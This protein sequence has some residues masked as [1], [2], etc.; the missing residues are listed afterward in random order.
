ME[1]EPFTWLTATLTEERG[2]EGPLGLPAD[3]SRMSAEQVALIPR[4]AECLE[5]WLPADEERWSG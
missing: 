2:Q 4:C 5:V 3:S 1:P